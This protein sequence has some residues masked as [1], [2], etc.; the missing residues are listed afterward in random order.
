[1]TSI[2]RPMRALSRPGTLARRM[3]DAVLGVLSEHE[4]N[5]EIPTSGRF[6]FYELEGRGIVRKSQRG[7]SRRGCADDPR[8]QEITDALGYLRDRDLI[9]WPWIVD[10]TRQL[11]EWNH[12]PFVADYV[13]DAVDRARINPWGGEPPL[14]L[15]ESRSLAGVL[16]PMASD[17]LV[18]IAA[19]NGQARGF[20]HTEIAP[21]MRDNDREAL[22]LGDWDHQGHQIEDNTRRVLEREAGREIHWTRVAIT[23]EQIAER[24]LTPIVKRDNRYSPALVHEAWETEALGQSTIVRLVREALDRLLP[25]PLADVQEREHAQREQ[26]RR[27]LA[28]IAA[29]PTSEKNSRPR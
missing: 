19:T 4:A 14:L 5:G 8:E 20:L 28:E 10:E 24:D 15:V 23:P 22:Y 6:V 16:R 18:P 25:E 27:V 26:L 2:H 1:M 13:T 17:Y 7:E 12:A 3:Q 21:I 9:P 11:Y 29:G